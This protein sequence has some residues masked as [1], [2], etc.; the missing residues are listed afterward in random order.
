MKSGN[1]K[2]CKD[3]T[4]KYGLYIASEKEVVKIQRLR[5]MDA[6]RYQMMHAVK[7]SLQVSYN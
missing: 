5:T 6:I 1:V 7:E 3:L 4:R 2:V